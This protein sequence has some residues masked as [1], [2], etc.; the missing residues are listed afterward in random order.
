[1]QLDLGNGQG[2]VRL[3]DLRQAFVPKAEVDSWR[4][5][6]GVYADEKRVLEGHL[7]QMLQALP[8]HPQPQTQ[9]QQPGGKPPIDYSGDELLNP[10]YQQSVE[11]MRVASENARAIDELKKLATQNGQMWQALPQLIMLG[12]MKQSNPALDLDALNRFRQEHHIND[13]VLASRAMNYEADMARVR[14][15]TEA[16]T[17]ERARQE[18]QLQNPQVPYAPYGPPHTMQVPAPGFKTIDEAEVAALQDQDILKMFYQ[19]MAAA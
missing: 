5:R 9:T 3:G 6:A 7:A 10:I 16:A 8:Q 12:Q 1:M 4:Q 15:E 14:A 11:A 2:V 17:L 18:L 13:P 19:P